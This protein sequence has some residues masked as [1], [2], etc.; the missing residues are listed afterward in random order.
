MKR[1]IVAA[2]AVM[3]ALPASAI[4]ATPSGTVLSVDAGHHSMQVIDGHHLAH[5]YRW[6]GRLPKL[7][8]GSKISFSRSGQT[9]SH[10]RASAG[11]SVSFYGRVMRSSASGLVL[12]LNDGAAVTFTSKQVARKHLSA[13]WHTVR[14]S[15]T[16]GVRV[17]TGGVTLNV[18]GLEPGVTVLVTET[19]VNGHK[20]VT[21]TLPTASAP[22]AGGEQ[23]AAGVIEEVDDD[24]F[25]LQ[26]PDGSQLRL[27]LDSTTLANLDLQVCD[28]ATASYHQDAGILI[29]DNVS[30]G[31][32]SAVGDCADGQDAVGTITQVAAT[33]LTISVAGGRS[34][35]FTVDPADDLTDGFAVGDLVDV[36]YDA[37]NGALAASDVEYVE[38]DSGGPVTAVSDGSITFTDSDT[39]QSLTIVADPSEEMFDGVSVGDGV[40]ITYHQSAGQLIADVVDDETAGN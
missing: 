20:T 34:L 17:T 26:A 39:G 16:G 30:D 18:Q 13:R 7:H 4:A 21:V 2:A 3:L 11:S 23:H 8:P 28:G 5:A 27:H 10:V 25:V 40:V 6:R 9:I 36:T 31:G 12:R 1:L 19:I 15:R 29:A 14:R 22:V 35:T 33:G 32:P 37:A 38:T 24:A